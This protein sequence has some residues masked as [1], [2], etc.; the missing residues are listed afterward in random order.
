M[1]H[2][3]DDRLAEIQERLGGVNS[4]DGE[5][6]NAVRYELD[7]LA[8]ADDSESLFDHVDT[9]ECNIIVMREGATRSK[10]ASVRFRDSSRWHVKPTVREALREA[11]SELMEFK[12]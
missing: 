5:I 10:S 1:K 7:R 3:L 11:L 4:P 9:Y 8:R 6:I 2:T 12:K